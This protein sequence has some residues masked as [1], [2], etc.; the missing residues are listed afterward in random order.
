MPVTPLIVRTRQNEEKRGR[1]PYPARKYMVA[2]EEEREMIRVI[3]AD[4]EHKVCQLICQLIDWDGL[5]ME[6][7][8]TASNGIEALQMIQEKKPDLVLT[9]IRM[10]G[11]D[12]MELLEKVRA[13]NQEVEFIVISGYSQFKYAQTAIRYGVK[14]YILKP[15]NKEML[16]ATLQKVR[17]RYLE[18]QDRLESD[19]IQAER[20]RKDQEQLRNIFWLDA[21]FGTIPDRMDSINRKY[22]F[23]FE[24][25]QFRT[26]LIH[27]DVKGVEDLNEPH[28]GN[29]LDL[30]HSKSMILIG[31]R[32][33]PLCIEMEAFHND[34]EI[35]G[36]LNYSSIK[37]KE[38]KD[39]LAAL[40]SRLCVEMQV[41]HYMQFHISVSLPFRSFDG[42]NDAVLQAEY[43][44]GQRLY[45]RGGTLL[46]VIPEDREFDADKLYKPF[47]VAIRQSYD[48]QS[49][50]KI[51]QAVVQL[52]EMAQRYD[53]NG[54]QMIRLVKECYRVFLLSSFFHQDYQMDDQEALETSFNKKVLLCGSVD[55][56]FAFLC[57]TCIRDLDKA[58]TYINREKIRPISQ[59]KQYI[60]EHYAAPLSL[61][62]VS[63]AVGFSSSY[64]S[65]IFHK[66]TGMTFLEYLTDIRMEEAKTLLR[67]SRMTIELVC[68][69]VGFHDTKRFSKTFRKATGLSPKEYR[70]LYS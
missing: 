30:F 60:Q 56:L 58:C 39:A 31:E 63:S 51:R 14:D 50:E 21:S 10:P 69:T 20:Q 12:G 57:E 49:M 32:L 34:C 42:F 8:G 38:M 37:E 5:G 55:T 52:Q 2:K 33:R 35:N 62:E 23:H 22:H 27:A 36:I 15:I 68:K 54:V 61:D 53:L 59:A 9:D 11:Y 46:E 16:N 6:L 4:D 70:N 25:E 43:A 41:F 28:A 7:V 13:D 66:E 47:S 3:V 67:E 45:D 18:R 44:M 29:V 64:F 1:L 26:F 24:P 17:Q 40:L 65:T 48:T 19:R